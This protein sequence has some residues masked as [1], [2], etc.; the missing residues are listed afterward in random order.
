MR[1]RRKPNLI[2]RVALFDRKNKKSKS[3]SVYD[4]TVE[5]LHDFFIKKLKEKIAENE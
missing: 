5:E 1:L 4:V 2:V 3:F